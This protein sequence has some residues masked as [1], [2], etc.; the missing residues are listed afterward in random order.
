MVDTQDVKSAK[1]TLKSEK[2][3]WTVASTP[4]VANVARGGGALNVTCEKPEYETSNQ[5][6]GEEFE[7]MTLGNILFGGVIGIAVDAASG[8]AF[9][10]PDNISILMRPLGDNKLI[11]ENKQNSLSELP[12][13]SPRRHT[14]NLAYITEEKL[15]N[16]QG[17]WRGYRGAG[18]VEI[19][20]QLA[21]TTAE[22]KISGTRL[23]L[24]LSHEV[25]AGS[26]DG[27]G[28]KADDYFTDSTTLR[29]DPGY[30]GVNFVEVKL[31]LETGQMIISYDGLCS[32]KLKKTYRATI[33]NDFKGKKAVRLSTHQ[34]TL[35]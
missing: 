28:L 7:Q 35:N 6:V 17:N 20:A 21:D 22:A 12:E 32:F 18:C 2:G 11:E 25:R 23:Q 26:D 27:T 29:F 30:Q 16:F 31:A 19:Y 24:K 1:C 3:S 8:S 5:L 9:K 14:E 13:K 33:A 4:G 10:Y 15:A 34:V